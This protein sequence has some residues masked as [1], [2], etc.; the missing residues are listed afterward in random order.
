MLLKWVTR[1]CCYTRDNSRLSCLL[2]VSNIN[3]SPYSQAVL[4][5]QVL[6]F[7]PLQLGPPFSGPAFSGPAFSAPPWVNIISALWALTGRQ[8]PQGRYNVY[9][10]PGLQFVHMSKLL[11]LLYRSGRGTVSVACVCIDVCYLR[12]KGGG[13]VIVLSVCQSVSLSVCLSACHSD[14]LWA[15]LLKSNQLIALK[16]GVMIGLTIYGE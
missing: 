13:Y 6:H 7:P 4:H 5:F 9:P 8:G 14:I 16:L 2:I 15:G 12:Q 11:L 3:G 10:C 1:Q